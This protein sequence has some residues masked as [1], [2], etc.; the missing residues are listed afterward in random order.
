[1]PST[2]NEL[3]LAREE[4]VLLTPLTAPARFLPANGKLSSVECDEMEVT[5]PDYPG[6]R[7][8]VRPSGRKLTL[9]CDLAILAFGF[10]NIPVPGIPSDSQGRILVDRSYA[11]PLTNVYAGGDAVTGSASFM[12]AVAAGKDAA[13]SIFE[14]FSP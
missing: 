2:K 3:A 8:N 14:K 5:A 9:T 10:E 1:M 7:N 13:A 6:G 4:G 12:K 11:T